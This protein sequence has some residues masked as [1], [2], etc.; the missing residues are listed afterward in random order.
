MEGAI[1]QACAKLTYPTHEDV[2][3]RDGHQYQRDRDTRYRRAARARMAKP[4]FLPRFDRV[5]LRTG[6]VRLASTSAV[7]TQPRT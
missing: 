7:V 5:S 2:E 3:D 6:R 1:R 4:R